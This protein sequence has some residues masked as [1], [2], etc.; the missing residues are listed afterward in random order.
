[1]PPAAANQPPREDSL[2]SRCS[3]YQTAITTVAATESALVVD[4]TALG[5]PSF[6]FYAWTTFSRAERP[7]DLQVSDTQFQALIHLNEHRDLLTDC[8]SPLPKIQPVT[9]DSLMAIFQGHRDGWS[10]FHQRYSGARRFLLVSQPLHLNGSSVLIYVAYAS[11][12]LNGAG[13][14]LR[15][16]RD[17]AGHWVLKGTATLWVS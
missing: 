3:I 16:E 10:R 12:W 7:Q 9:S 6:A 14:I 5:V 1:M 17:R 2:S 8:L 15:L 13:Q 11:D 4:S